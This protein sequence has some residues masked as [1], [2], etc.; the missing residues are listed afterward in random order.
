MPRTL[1]IK[2][3]FVPLPAPGAPP[4]KINSLGNR[5]LLR[6]NSSSNSRQTALKMSWASL[7]SRSGEFVIMD[8]QVNGISYH[9]TFSAH[10]PCD[11]V[12]SMKALRPFRSGNPW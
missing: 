5:I 12:P 7:T 11:C 1:R 2:S 6:P 10:L 8:T 3:E 4:S 9:S